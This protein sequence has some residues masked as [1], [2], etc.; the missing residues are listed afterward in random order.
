MFLSGVFEVN[1][2]QWEYVSGASV[3]Y[4]WIPTDVII[5]WAQDCN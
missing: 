4:M 3:H 2:T 1:E 5:I